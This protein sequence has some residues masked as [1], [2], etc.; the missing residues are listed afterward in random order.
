MAIITR[1]RMPPENWCGYSLIRSWT[2]GMPTRSRTSAALSMACSLDTSRCRE[3][4]S[5]ICL[6]TVMVGFSEVSGSWKIMPISLPRIFRICSSDK[7]VRSWPLS[8]M[9]PVAMCPPVGSRFMIDKAVIVLP[10][11]DSPTMPRVSPG[12]SWNETPSTAC[13][14]PSRSLIWV[15]RSLTSSSGA[16]RSPFSYRRCSR[17]SKASRSASPMK[18]KDTTVAMM[19]RPA[20]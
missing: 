10:Q 18:L 6:P 17:V 20:G 2:R 19:T 9:L 13:T 14:T 8:L 7:A 11:P 16:T 4:A 3:T 1:W 5:A 12:S 15:R